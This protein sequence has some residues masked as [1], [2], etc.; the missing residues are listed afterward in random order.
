MFN[1]HDARCCMCIAGACVLPLHLFHHCMCFAIACV[2]P[3]HVLLHS[4]CSY[5]LWCSS[6]TMA[7]GAQDVANVSAPPDSTSQSQ[8]EFEMCLS[9]RMVSARHLAPITS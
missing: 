7:L 5:F 8:M 4:D 9:Q 1:C 3:L 6:P 2:L